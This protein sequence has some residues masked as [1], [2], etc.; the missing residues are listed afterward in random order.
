MSSKNK[1]II[2]LTKAEIDS[3][4]KQFLEEIDKMLDRVRIR[5]RKVTK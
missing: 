5:D 2:D 4:Q 3:I 1:F